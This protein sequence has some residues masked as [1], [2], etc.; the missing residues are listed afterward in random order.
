M[1]ANLNN[2]IGFGFVPPVYFSKWPPSVNTMAS[3]W[4]LNGRH[5]FLAKSSDMLAHSSS[6]EALRSSTDLWGVAHAFLSTVQSHTV[7][8]A[9][10]NYAKLLE[11]HSWTIFA[12]WAGAKSC[13]QQ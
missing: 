11:H 5:T 13:C 6:T 12:L 1:R 9:G 7:G 2:R 3:R 10:Q 4:G 8:G